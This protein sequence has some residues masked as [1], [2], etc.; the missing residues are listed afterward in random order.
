LPPSAQSNVDE[1]RTRLEARFEI[2]PIA[3][4]MVL[5][6]RFKTSIRSIELSDSTIAIDGAPVT[7]RELSDR[8][9]PG[10][11]RYGAAAF[12]SRLAGAAVAGDRKDASSE[13]VD[14][15]ARR[16]SIPVQRTAWSPRSL[17]HRG[18]RRAKTSLRIGGS[19]SVDSDEYVRGDVV[20]HRRKR[21]HQRRSE[22]RGRR[23]RG[24]P[25]GSGRRPTL[26]GDI[27]V[28]VEALRETRRGHAR[29][30]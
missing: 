2:V 8:L 1:L 4:G 3:N 5:T 30:D 12:V 13:P 29:R 17:A 18:P 10:R 15:T 26:R 19:V 22:R 24:N 25:R 27:T 28:S 16:R 11:H 6:P 9:G 7:G 20:C 21:E 14:A 23:R